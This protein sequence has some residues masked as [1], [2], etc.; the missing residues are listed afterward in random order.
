MSEISN[1]AWSSLE[2]TLQ[3]H[4]GVFFLVAQSTTLYSYCHVLDVCPTSVFTSNVHVAVSIERTG[5]TSIFMRM[6]ETGV[7]TVGR[8]VEM[9]GKICLSFLGVG[10]CVCILMVQNYF[11]KCKVIKW[12]SAP[13]FTTESLYLRI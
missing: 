1:N 11:V 7:F 6:A 4:L 2:H 13:R 9:S 10:F 12:Q 3:E 8:T 5:Y